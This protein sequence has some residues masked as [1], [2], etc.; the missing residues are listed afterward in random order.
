MMKKLNDIPVKNPF[1]VPDN[2]FEEVNRKIISVTSDSDKEVRKISFYNR[3]RTSLLI[4]ASVAGL[5]LISYTAI[6]LLTHDKSNSQV[7][8]VLHEMNPDMYMND[9]DLSSLEENA[10]SLVLSDEGPDVSKKDIIDYLLQENVEL[11]DI[12]EHL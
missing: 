2:Y 1:K 6:K 5:I 9:I 8:E 3:F 12:Y 11:N 4:A 7:S 10:S